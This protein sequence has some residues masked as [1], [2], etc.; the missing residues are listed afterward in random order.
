MTSD[1][2]YDDPGDGFGDDIFRPEDQ[3]TDDDLSE[4]EKELEHEL[5]KYQGQSSGSVSEDISV[6]L[7]GKDPGTDPGNISERV[8]GNVS[9]K[10]S[11]NI[12][13]NV[14]GKYSGDDVFSGASGLSGIAD[15]SGGNETVPSAA[16]DAYGIVTVGIAPLEITDLGAEIV[17]YITVNR[18]SDV[19]LGGYVTVPYDASSSGPED[20]FAR[21]GK[22]RYCQQY[23]SDD[24]NEIHAGR[25]IAGQKSR[26]SEDD[27]KFLVYLDPICIL[28]RKGNIRLRRMT[29][30]IPSPN[31]SILPVRDKDMIRTG[32][33]LPQSGLFLGHLS[34]GGEIVRTHAYPP[35]VAYY[36]RNDYTAGDPLIFRH[37]L[38]CG[39]TGTGKTFLTKNIL[40]Q[41]M[42]DDNRYRL[43]ADHAVRKRPCLVLMDPQ[44]EYSQIFEDNPEIGED[45]KR[46]L[47]AE[48]IAFGGVEDTRTFT[49]KVT[50]E[51]YRGRSL[52]EQIEFTIPFSFVEKNPWILE[53]SELTDNQKMGTELLLADY[54]RSAKDTGTVPT[55]SGFRDFVEDP[56]TK[57]YYTEE[58][59]KI[60]E[61]SYGGITRKVLNRTY[62][63]IFDQDAPAVTDILGKIFKDGRVS[64]FPTEY[65][66][67]SRIRDLIVLVIM[68]II[69]DNKLSTSGT[70]TIKNTPIILA[71]DEAHR[72]LSKAEGIQSE[73]II[74][75]FAEAAKQGR[76]E[77]LGLF[78]ITQD[79]QDIEKEILK[80]INTKIVLNLSNDAAIKA[81]NIPA[82]Y[83]K[84][85]PYLKKG[86]MIIH[87]PDNSDV[88]EITGL[89]VCTVMHK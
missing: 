70:E 25:M 79:P 3:D 84:R 10:V 2:F 85:I 43:R 72:Y 22:I 89:P 11:G 35:T 58:S 52:A 20:L 49:A 61:S 45:T 64:V 68:T 24:A 40:R 46:R 69:V 32:L 75:K 44:D 51:K 4:L 65:I 29:D 5:N 34:V 13:G 81:V 60:H 7:S 82:E 57:Q 6:R 41:F 83:E 73:K 18:R 19:R 62:E 17:G 33:N 88:V 66:S 42:G 27:Y 67:S 39:S 55:Y 76:K 80:Q 63:R 23:I 12:S 15:L 1:T 86:Q 26:I 77:G 50:G 30:R 8:S 47:D 36:L 31:A 71:L 38:V 53:V 16:G 9:E 54:F 59:G 28:Y 87:S 14:S 78:L 56:A 37:M 48:N 21:I 74:S